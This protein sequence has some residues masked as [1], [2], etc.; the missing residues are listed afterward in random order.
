MVAAFSEEAADAVPDV[1]SG[2]VNDELLEVRD[3]VSRITESPARPLVGGLRRTPRPSVDV[4]RLS[5]VDAG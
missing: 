3:T 5:S 1:T 2:D 4:S